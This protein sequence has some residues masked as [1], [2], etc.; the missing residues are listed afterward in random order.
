[1]KNQRQWLLKGVLTNYKNFAI[2]QGIISTTRNTP[3]MYQNVLIITA[4]KRSCG[5]VM[6]YRCLSVWGNLWS[7]VL[8]GGWVGISGIRSLLGVDVSWRQ[9][10][11]REGPVCLGVGMSTGYVQRRVV[12]VQRGGYPPTPTLDMEPGI[13]RDTIGKLVV[14]ILLECCLVLYLFIGCWQW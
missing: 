8:S 9:G 13:P 7:H 1:M 2:M 5:K 11:F 12:Y 6:F 4:R 14:H 3:Q 10:V